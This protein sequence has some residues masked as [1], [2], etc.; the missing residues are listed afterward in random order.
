M[1][2]ETDLAETQENMREVTPTEHF[3]DL[4]VPFAHPLLVRCR[5]AS[6]SEAAPAVHR[7]YRPLPVQ[8]QAD[9]EVENADGQHG[10]QEEGHRGDQD[11]QVVHPGGLDYS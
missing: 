9:E 4:R 8:P 3:G 7:G 1:F 5:Q 2:F 11:D 6:R 10:E